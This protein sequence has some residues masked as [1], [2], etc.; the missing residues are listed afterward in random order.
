M[1]LFIYLHLG[2]K[3]YGPDAV[4]DG[5]FVSHNLISA[6]E[7]LVPS[8]QFQM[9]PRLRLWISSRSKQKEPRYACLSEGKA[10]HS[11]SVWAEV[12]S[13]A[14]RLLTNGLSDNPIKWWCLLKVLCPVRRRATALDCVLLKDRNLALVTG[15]GPE[16]NSRVCLWA[17][18]RLH[19]H[20]QCWLTNQ[21]LILLLISCLKTPKAGSGPT[22]FTA[23]PSLASSSGILFPPTPARPETEKLL[24]SWSI[25]NAHFMVLWVSVPCL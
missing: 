25:N 20:T 10:S 1:Y 3:P 4:T 12:S 13:S 23:E 17:L 14:P 8:L 15:Q 2:S 9:A 7:S 18:P 16:I 21:H 24:V 6:Q 5:P 22:N 11:Q 19:H